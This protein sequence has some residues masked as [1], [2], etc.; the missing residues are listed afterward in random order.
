MRDKIV[1]M[2]DG[3]AGTAVLTGSYKNIPIRIPFIV[4][5]F[6]IEEEKNPNSTE[7]RSIFHM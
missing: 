7:A 5:G 3:E 4:K 1:L 6:Q 2:A